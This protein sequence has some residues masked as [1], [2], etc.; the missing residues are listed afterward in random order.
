MTISAFVLTTNAIERQYP[1]VEC[2]RSYLPFCD[3]IIVVDGGSTDGT[4]EAIE[5]IHNS[6]IRIIQD[7]DTEWEK[8]W[9]YWRMSH[10]LNR[11]YEE[12]QGDWAIKVDADF[13]MHESCYEPLKEYFE[14]ATKDEKL[15]TTFARR[16][17]I[18]MDS[19]YI[20]KWNLFAVNKAL[21]R[22][23]E[24]DVKYGL[25]LGNWGWG[26]QPVI[27]EEKTFK[28]WHGTLLTNRENRLMT[29]A[30][31]FNYSYAFRTREMACQIISRQMLAV[32]RQKI[33][34]GSEEA[35]KELQSYM[36]NPEVY[37]NWYIDGY[38]G[39]MRKRQ[40]PLASPDNHPKVIQDK[41]RDLK[42]EQGGW[43]LWGELGTAKYYK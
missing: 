23:K 35:K 16:N 32:V 12:C 13:V 7:E 27:A 17:I 5:N 42:P 30:N 18:L 31:I 24:I 22:T 28:I 34:G 40:F 8:E 25:D 41:V 1:I 15:T 10:N 33:L 20:K 37:L 3:E 6:R 11:G 21:C 19:Y 38:K 39:Y 26:N 4:I 29:C 14:N 2:L 43:N 36:D 9:A